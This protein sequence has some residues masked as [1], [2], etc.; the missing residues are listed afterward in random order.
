MVVL[1]TTLAF[2][3]AS[4]SAEVYYKIN[5]CCKSHKA[6]CQYRDEIKAIE[7]RLKT[8]SVETDKI[9]NDGKT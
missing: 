3:L 9:A 1:A 6:V 5:G 2:S 4:L 7:A 8:L